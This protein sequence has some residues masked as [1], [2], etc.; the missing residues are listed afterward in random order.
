MRVS[1]ICTA[2]SCRSTLS[3]TMLN[4]LAPPDFKVCSADSQPSGRVHPRNLAT[5][6]Q[7]DIAAHSLYSGGSKAFEGT[8]PDTIITICGTTTGEACPLYLDATLKARWGLADPFTLDGDRA[9]W[10]AALCTTLA[11]I[12]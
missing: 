3:E 11:C 2:S 7:A 4:R 10:G 8:P 6:G 12:G 1:F 5:L 9:L